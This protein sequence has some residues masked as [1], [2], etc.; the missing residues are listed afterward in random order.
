MLVVQATPDQPIYNMLIRLAKGRGQTD[1]PSDFVYPIHFWGGGG[2]NRPTR[3]SLLLPFGLHWWSSHQIYE[4]WQY[5]RSYD[6]PFHI[7]LIG[8]CLCHNKAASIWK[9][10]SRLQSS[11][12]CGSDLGVGREKGLSCQT[13]D[14]AGN[15]DL[16]G[17]PQWSWL[18][19]D[20]SLWII[21]VTKECFISAR[22]EKEYSRHDKWEDNEDVFG[23]AQWV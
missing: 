11:T 21:F 2:A 5:L 19:K 7:S 17:C 18:R 9:T 13:V 20:P 3:W 16:F 12:F 8:L 14:N 23:C 1:S 6:D 4:T 15:K 22:Y 10:W